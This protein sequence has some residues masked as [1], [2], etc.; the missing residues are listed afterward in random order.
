MFGESSFL[1]VI[2][3]Q[4]SFKYERCGFKDGEVV[5]MEVVTQEGFDV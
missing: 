4:L 3:K 5:D 1:G 2:E